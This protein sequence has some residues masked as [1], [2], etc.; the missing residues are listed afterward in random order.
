MVL[1]TNHQGSPSCKSKF[2][3]QQLPTPP[4]APGGLPCA[5]QIGHPPLRYLTEVES[6]PVCP[7]VSGFSH[8]AGLRGSTVMY[9]E[10]EV[11]FFSRLDNI[12]LCR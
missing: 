2:Q 7:S 8:L 3:M 9:H 11:P 10:S 4:P 12:P 6:D 1:A 5:L